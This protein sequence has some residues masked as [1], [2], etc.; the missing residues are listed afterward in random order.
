MADPIPLAQSASATLTL[1]PALA[2]RHGL[3][4]GATG[5]GKTVT[6]QT[7]AEG[8]SRIGVP[9]FMADVKGDLSGL[10]AAG[11]MSARFQQHLEALQISDWSPHAFPTVF[12]DVYGQDGHPV[13]ATITDMGPVLLAR[14]LNLNDT[15]AGVLQ[16]A[17]KIADDHGLLL[18]DLKD[19]RAMIQFVGENARQLTIEY[20]NVSAASIGAIQRNLLVL[21]EQGGDIFFGEPMLEIAD[22]MQTD[23][24]GK[25]VINIMAAEKLTRQP[26][27]YAIFLLWLLSELFERLPEVGD[28]EKPKL[29]FFFDEAHLLF[30]AA[31][32]ALLEK[33]EQVVRLIRSKG[34]GIYFVTQNPLD[35]PDSVLGQLGNRV[36]HALRAF[37]PRDEKAVQTAARTMRANPAFDAAKAITE[38]G[39][40]EA[41]VSFLDE[42]GR[43]NIVARAFVLPPTSRIGP[44]SAGERERVIKSSRL[45]GHYEAAVDRESAFELIQAKPQ[46][47]AAPARTTTAPTA[48]PEGSG[49]G[50]LGGL[51]DA[52]GGILGSGGTARRGSTRQGVGEALI[53]SA[54]RSIGSQLGGAI[55]RGVLGSILG[56]RK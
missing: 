28:P 30:S 54:A 42:Q 46:A 38:L 51:G 43:P 55:V 19:L 37:T 3:I 45:Y 7:M 53:K 36:Q 6:L 5:T 2:N 56:G 40:G 49:G 16:L 52:L 15:Q 1:L 34:V 17:F 24:D 23:S 4:T 18:L 48:A 13:R 32:P 14:L 11:Q 25:G 26:R 12:W 39:A 41:L 10:A 31:S 33:I 29:V 47:A 9:V 22:L 27:L 20:G 44:L 35:V 8:F 50:L 21:G